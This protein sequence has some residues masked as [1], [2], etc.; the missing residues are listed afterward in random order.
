MN[1]TNIFKHVQIDLKHCSA[2]GF[3]LENVSCQ[4]SFR[5]FVRVLPSM[6][7]FLHAG[8]LALYTNW[9]LRSVRLFSLYTFL[10]LDCFFWHHSMAL[11]LPLEV[12]NWLWVRINVEDG[13]DGVDE[14]EGL[15][16]ECGFYYCGQQS[17]SS[18]WRDK[19]WSESQGPQKWFLFDFFF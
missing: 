8:Q 18:V 5:D 19:R 10:V 16:W 17:F 2:P 15:F 4:I 9:I 3:I 1:L 7:L 12:C 13:R 11:S 6:L 14:V